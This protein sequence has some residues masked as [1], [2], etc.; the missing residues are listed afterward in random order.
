MKFKTL[1]LIF[2]V[3][4]STSAFSAGNTGLAFLKIGAGA[5]AT[6]MGEAFVAIANDASGV[7]WNPGALPWVNE[8]QVHFTHNKWIQDVTNEA[9]SVVVPSSIGAFGVSA[10]L[11]NIDGIEQRTIP[12]Q[13]P[14]GEVS[15]HDFS[16]GLSYGRMFGQKL[17]VGATAKFINEK[18]YLQN[19][20]GYA[21]DFGFRF[22][23]FSSGIYV[24]GAV[25]NMGSMSEL[26]K[27]S[28]KLPAL[29]RFGVA[30][31]VPVSKRNVL[32][33][34]DFV[35]VF[36]EE[37]H[38]NLGMEIQPI[39]MLKLRDGYQTGYD[40]RDLTTGF[41]LAVGQFFLDYAYV[42]FDSDLGNSQ[43]FSFAI[44]F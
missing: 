13:E 25:M 39:K 38:L 8:K 35:K 24:G 44:V 17:S 1:F 28:I 29:M 14:L 34:A 26:F 4:L 11:T 37:S 42:P 32:L 16:F 22:Q 40:E 43:R 5:R 36:E 6:A 2:I 9:V 15:A 30:Y 21:V 7:F 31:N 12:S 23:P 41:G 18:I 19:A 33:S 27:E 3:F 20:N 10:M